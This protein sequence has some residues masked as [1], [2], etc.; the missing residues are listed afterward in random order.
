MYV[1]SLGELTLRIC[2]LLRD[3]A[4]NPYGESSTIKVCSGKQLIIDI[5]FQYISGCG[6]EFFTS[7]FDMI[8]SIY[9]IISSLAKTVNTVFLILF[10]QTANL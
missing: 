6:F 10:E 7:S 9:S 4:N 8:K 5:A 2:D 3:A 1:I